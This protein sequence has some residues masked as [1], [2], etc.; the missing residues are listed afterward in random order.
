MAIVA[1]KLNSPCVGTKC[2]KIVFTD[3][4]SLYDSALKP[5]GWS[6]TANPG[7]VTMAD[8]LSSRIVLTVDGDTTNY[9]FYPKINTTNLYPANPT[10]SFSFAEFD[11]NGAD[12]IYNLSYTAN[13]TVGNTAETFTKKVLIT[14]KTE[15][16][17][18]KLYQ[19]YLSE[20]TINAKNAWLDATDMLEG[21]KMSFLCNS[22]TET[23]SILTSLSKICSLSDSNCG[24][25]C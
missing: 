6:G 24:C 20:K 17:I 23:K 7:G 22:L 3:S 21:A 4:T 13:L 25:G 12:G 8:I 9:V 1:L 11:W 14:C 18:K 10:E 5:K 2:T 19:K 15:A 16:C